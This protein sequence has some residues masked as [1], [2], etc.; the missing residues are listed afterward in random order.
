MTEENVEG[1][2]NSDEGATRDTLLRK[3]YEGE[4]IGEAMYA[5]LADI[6]E[7]DYQR[8]AARLA[9]D[10]ERATADLLLP[11]IA[12]H[13]VAVDPDRAKQVGIDF[14][15]DNIPQGWSNYFAKIQ[16]LAEQALVGMERLHQL[17]DEADESAT[18]RLVAHEHALLEFIRRDLAGA[19]DPVE[20]LQR[21]LDAE[22]ELI[23][24]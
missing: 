22:R 11:L 21:F 12:R 6:A 14:T 20:P 15:N 3:A 5:L 24:Q 16:P 18:G 10:V 8:K 2:V 4:I 17:S 13:G 7:D 23:G 9:A 1:V 19:A